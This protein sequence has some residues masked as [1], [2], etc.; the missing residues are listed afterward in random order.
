MKYAFLFYFIFVCIRFFYGVKGFLFL[1]IKIPVGFSELIHEV[2]LGVVIGK[3]G[4]YINEE[5]AMEHVMGYVL[6]L[7]MTAKVP[8]PEK[9]HYKWLLAKG[10]DTA[11]PISN[12]IPK[13]AVKCEENVSLQLKVNGHLRQDGNTCDML[14]KIPQLISYI[15]QFFRLEYGDLLLTG[16]PLGNLTVKHGDIIEAYMDDIAYINCRVS[17]AKNHY[18]YHPHNDESSA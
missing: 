4:K 10:F 12:F 3:D 11:T 8:D 15:S 13:A 18:N 2:E 16:T 9:L 6:A 5:N 7:D 17:K 14:F 1:K